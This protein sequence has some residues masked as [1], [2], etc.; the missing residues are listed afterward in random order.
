MYLNRLYEQD[1][2]E[3]MQ[4]LPNDCV[5]L[6]Y[7]DILYGTGK[8]FGEYKDLPYNK[9]KIYEFYR[10][11]IQQMYR[12]LRESG[13]LALQMDYR[14]S[15]WIRDICD[16]FFG[17]KNCM[18]VIQ[19]SYGS[20]GKPKG[21]LSCKNDEIIIYAKNRYKQKFNPMK[22]RSY[23][24]NDKPYGFKDVEEWSDENGRW[25]TLV[26]MRCIWDIPMVGRSSKERTGYPTQKP[27]ELT[28]R[29]RDL[30]T[31]RGDTIADFFMGSGGMIISSKL[32]NRMYIGCD[33]NDNAINIT[34]NRLNRLKGGRMA[35]KNI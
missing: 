9:K 13:T 15:H 19:W 3:L 22:Q 34:R 8:N 2:L 17:Y 7:S 31:D 4:S 10:P 35:D 28:N 24:R 6:I 29:I 1:N 12:L 21:K 33:K 20:G 25:Y 26:N 27:L 14:I 30:Y 18:N 11:R 5:N 23:N 32:G 16:G